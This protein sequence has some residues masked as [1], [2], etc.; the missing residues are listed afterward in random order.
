MGVALTQRAG[1]VLIYLCI[2]GLFAGGSASPQAGGVTIF[3]PEPLVGLHKLQARH[4]DPLS[5][6][7]KPRSNDQSVCL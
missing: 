6:S 5:G 3:Y 4:G 1:W 7:L 2:L